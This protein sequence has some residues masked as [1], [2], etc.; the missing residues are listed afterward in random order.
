MEVLNTWREHV[1]SVCTVLAC[2]NGWIKVKNED[3]VEFSVRGEIHLKV[4]KAAPEPDEPDDA[5]RP[6]RAKSAPKKIYQPVVEKPPARALRTT[7][8]LAVTSQG[9]M[10]PYGR[11]FGGGRY[12]GGPFAEEVA[13]D[14]TEVE[15]RLI[16]GDVVRGVIKYRTVEDWRGVTINVCQGLGRT[17][18]ENRR[19]YDVPECQL[20]E[21]VPV[22]PS[23]REGLR[24]DVLEML[25]RAVEEGDPEMCV[26]LHRLFLSLL[27]EFD[28][29]EALMAMYSRFCR[30]HGDLLRKNGS[31]VEISKVLYEKRERIVGGALCKASAQCDFDALLDLGE[32]APDVPLAAFGLYTV[33]P[34]GSTAKE[35]EFAEAA[36]DYSRGTVKMHLIN[37]AF[38]RGGSCLTLVAGEPGRLPVL[39]R[40]YTRFTRQA[41]PSIKT[42]DN[43]REHLVLACF[44]NT[45]IVG[46]ASGNFRVNGTLCGRVKS[47]ACM[48][49]FA[50]H[51]GLGD[52]VHR[53]CFVRA[54][55]SGLGMM[56]PVEE[57][58]ARRYGIAIS[59][60]K[61]ARKR[62]R[63]DS[64]TTVSLF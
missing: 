59:K 52:D 9:S 57:A 56:A 30:V 33:I 11:Q 4:I 32:A 17:Y 60:R 16:V 36:A 45:R 8:A 7:A 12:V 28:D 51:L 44:P 1:G 5:Q 34:P 55:G 29:D 14:D 62:A 47:D 22:A 37:G 48:I 26:C 19:V 58:F 31:V 3:G 23:Y 13:E 27:T 20:I 64:A 18:D 39:L 21:D 35:R 50:D 41:T 61:E 49:A 10:W 25:C 53:G 2:S 6:K 24:A 40:S 54:D 15:F 38:D 46:S 43:L 42:A 63:R